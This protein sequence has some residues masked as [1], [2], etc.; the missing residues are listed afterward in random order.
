MRVFSLSTKP[1][2]QFLSASLLNVFVGLAITV[3]NAINMALVFARRNGLVPVAIRTLMNVL[4]ELTTA[5][6][7]FNVSTIPEV[8]I[9]LP[10]LQAITMYTEM[11]PFVK[12]LMNVRRISTTAHHRLRIAQ[13]FLV[14][15]CVP[16]VLRAT[17]PYLKDAPRNTVVMVKLTPAN[18]VMADFA[19]FP[20]ARVL[21]DLARPQMFLWVVSQRAEMVE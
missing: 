18:N 13:I 9:A 8:T 4:L 15:T 14:A 17:F 19:V 6:L 11:A 7:W 10:V 2:V 1:Q 3:G 5:I 16:P 20:I 21:P 12:T